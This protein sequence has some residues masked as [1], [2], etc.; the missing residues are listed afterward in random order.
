[1]MLWKKTL[2]VVLASLGPLGHCYRQ[3]CWSK[4]SRAFRF[5]AFGISP[6]HRKQFL[7]KDLHGYFS[8]F[9]FSPFVPSIDSLL[10]GCRMWAVK[11]PWLIQLD[12]GE[13]VARCFRPCHL[14]RWRQLRRNKSF[15]YSS[16]FC[17][18]GDGKFWMA[19][20]V[21]GRLDIL[22]YMCIV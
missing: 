4:G 14:P 12:I 13:V 6:Y 8:V 19:R 10:L 9:F 17:R 22:L 18:F 1:M 7:V 20:Q 5:G 11:K 3:L 2:E 16:I 21:F 15:A